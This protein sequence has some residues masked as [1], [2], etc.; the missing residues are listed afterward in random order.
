MIAVPAGAAPRP[1]P[2]RA[3]PLPPGRPW[4][5]PPGRLGP[6]RAGGRGRSG[7]PSTRGAER[8][9]APVRSAILGTVLATVVLLATVTFGASLDHARRPIPSLYGWNWTYALSSGVSY[10]NHNQ[11]TAVLD[12]DPGGRRLDGRLVRHR[13]DRRRDRPRHRRGPERAGRAPAAVRPRACRRQ[14]RSCS[15]RTTLAQL[16]Q[17]RG[18]HG[19]GH[20]RRPAAVTRCG[21]SAP[22]PCPR[23]GIAATL[24]TEMG[25]GAVAALPGHSR[26]GRQ[27]AEQHP[28]HPAPRRQ[29]RRAAEAV[30]QTHRPGRRTAAWCCPCSARPRSPTTGPWAPR[31]LILGR[32]P[33]RSA[34]SA[35]LLAD[36][37]VASVRRRRRDLALLKT[38]GFTRRQLV[39]H[40]RLAVHHR[41]RRR[42]HRRRPARHRARPLRCGTCSPARSA[43]SPSRRSPAARSPS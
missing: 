3:V 15:A 13:A 22:P 18:R 37:D 12:H 14:G 35:S 5:V 28:G 17:A 34:R 25:T 27:P 6:A 32:R 16:Q 26:R 1:R 33:R 9:R 24:H 40:R 2:R 7:W 8:G 10:V 31:P 4:C 30:L 36:P 41:D 43:S 29:P 42:R 20:R 38:L 39:R 21:S 23:S 11:T 19:H